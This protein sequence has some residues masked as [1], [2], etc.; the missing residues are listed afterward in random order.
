MHA[1]LKH[2]PAP[3]AT[4]KGFCN[5]SCEAQKTLFL[6]CF[7]SSL[8][9]HARMLRNRRL[10]SA[11]FSTVLLATSILVFTSLH[12]RKNENVQ[13]IETPFVMDKTEK[14]EPNENGKPS[15]RSKL[16]NIAAYNRYSMKRFYFLLVYAKTV[17]S[18]FRA[19]WLKTFSFP[20]P[21]TEKVMERGRRD[22]CCIY[23]LFC[24]KFSKLCFLPM[25]WKIQQLFYSMLLNSPWFWP[26][27]PFAERTLRTRR[28][29]KI[30]ALC[31]CVH[32]QFPYFL[33]EHG[34]LPCNW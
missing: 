15:V 23:Q 5:W 30:F 2:V 10:R 31:S 6:A 13:F 18:V 24:N 9:Q 26:T 11:L 17:D 19:L 25:I 32:W 22:K 27:R 20:C 12:I 16:Q 7:P 8:S 29:L 3:T 1:S 33:K 34:T 28:Q 4:D 14:V 21:F